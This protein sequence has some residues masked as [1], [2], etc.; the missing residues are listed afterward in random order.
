[1]CIPMFVRGT[2]MPPED[3]CPRMSMAK[4]RSLS[5]PNSKASSEKKEPATAQPPTAQ[6]PAAHQ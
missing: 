6:V 2:K 4:I 1:M 5:R 3:E